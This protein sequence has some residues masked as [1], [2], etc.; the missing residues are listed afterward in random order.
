METVEHMARNTGG[1]RSHNAGLQRAGKVEAM[2]TQPGTI[3]LPRQSR[4][5]DLRTRRSQATLS[6]GTTLHARML[7]K[8]G[9]R[10][11]FG[12]IPLTTA[13]TTAVQK[14]WSLS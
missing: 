4:I 10:I 8:G 7:V 1:A 6:Q 5:P 2:E 11:T 14:L 12:A 9:V 3:A 13:G